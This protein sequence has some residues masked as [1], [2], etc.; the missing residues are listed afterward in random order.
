MERLP[1][2]KAVFHEALRMYPTLAIL[3]R[4]ARRATQVHDGC[5]LCQL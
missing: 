3:T 5:A 1:Y 2:A 4:E